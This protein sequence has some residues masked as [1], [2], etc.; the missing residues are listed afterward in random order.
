[1]KKK[2]YLLAADDYMKFKPATDTGVVLAKEILARGI[3]VDYLDLGQHDYKQDTKTYLSTLPVRPILKSDSSMWPLFE[4]G[5]VRRA[6]VSEY[7]VILQRKDPPV[8][9]IYIGHCKHFSHA[10]KDIVQMNNPD[11]T[12]RLSE[13]ELPA[14]YPKYGVPTKKCHSFEDL[15][16][17]VRSFQGDIVVKP[18]NLSS[19]VG[20]EF[21]SSQ[22]DEKTLKAFW[23]KW[24]PA[25]IV[26]PYME[27]ITTIGD[28]RIMVMNQKIIG[29]V[30]RKPKPGSRIANL[31]QGGSAHGWELTPQ[32]IEA[33]LAVAKDLTPK[34]LWLLGLDFIG[35]YISEINITCPSTV[36]QVNQVLN[37]KI[38]V[39][40]IDELEKLS[41][42]N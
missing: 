12:W 16:K 36:I 10:P 20:V 41:A 3:E 30:L 26:Q 38:E 14:M 39:D 23:D 21:L 7:T 15:V 32:Q 17:A 25:A 1:M 27:E 5:P 33:S 8:D 42:Q 22:T 35:N 19:G 24:K 13:H 31:H 34:G 40:I 29:W 6:N 9:E 28:L 4:L 18:D 2:R 37:R 11:M